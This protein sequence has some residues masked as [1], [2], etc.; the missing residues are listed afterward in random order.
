MLATIEAIEVGEA[1]FQDTGDELLNG[2]FA[3]VA[4]HLNM[5]TGIFIIWTISIVTL[6]VG[7]AYLVKSR[8]KAQN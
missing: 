8:K 4:S 1:V 3:S 2:L 5:S 7:I 6:A